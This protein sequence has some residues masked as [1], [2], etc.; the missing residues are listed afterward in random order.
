MEAPP[1]NATPWMYCRQCG[2]A[3]VGL[4]S[5]RYPECGRDFDA[6]DPRTFLR[7]PR[8]IVLRRVLKIGGVLLCLLLGVATYV[9]YLDWQVRQE[10]KAMAFLSANWATVT[11][12]DTTPTWARMILRGRAAWLW[13]RADRV[14]LLPPVATGQMSLILAAVAKLR[15][16]R[17]LNL[18]QTPVTDA[19]LEQ[20]K[21]LTALQE[22]NVNLVN[23]TDA[24]LEHLKGMTGLKELDLRGTEVTDA[25]V[26]HLKGLT[27]LQ[28]LDVTGTKVTDAGVAALRKAIP[29]IEIYH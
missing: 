24:G 8:R 10:A 15:Y 26:E 23:V 19:G 25:G 20:L 17:T 6:N 9:G 27:G 21:G 28:W 5:N 11:T 16:L 22:L 3:L 18:S 12:Y 29:G 2:Y 14:A 13:E 1:A 4:S 7:R